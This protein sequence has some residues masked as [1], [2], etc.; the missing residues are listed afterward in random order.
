M[1]ELT[2][3][4]GWL[5]RG[6]RAKDAGAFTLIELLVVIAIIAILA[7]MLLPALAKAKCKANTTYCLSN[8]RQLQI[9]AGMYGTDFNDA[10]VPNA[11]LAGSWAAIGWCNGAYGESWASAPANVDPSYYTTNCLAS[12]VAN[13]LKVYKCPADNIPSDNGDRIR[14]VSMNGQMGIYKPVGAGSPGTPYGDSYNPGWR[15]YRKIPE[16]TCPTPAN[17]WIFC[18]ES[19]YTLNDGFMQMNLNSPDFP[20]VPANYNCQGNCFTFADGHGEV[21]KWKGLL[22]FTPY[23]KGVTMPP[24]LTPSA[25][26]LDWLWLREHSACQLPP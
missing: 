20:D 9:A 4:R 7:A 10:L 14:T 15:N 18:D 22:R 19:M 16:L 1:K 17:A 26:D 21:H 2:Q 11:P 6:Y 25:S 24:R 3:T 23:A 12:Y 8:K 13:N 5:R